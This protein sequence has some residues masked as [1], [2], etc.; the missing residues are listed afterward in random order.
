M[1]PIPTS[2]GI[3][4]PIS[5]MPIDP[6]VAIGKIIS[7][8]VGFILVFASIW[9]LFQLLQAGLQ[10]IGSGGDKAGLEGARDRITHS[11]LGLLVV[12]SAW[13]IYILVLSFLGLSPIG[14]SGTVNFKIPSFF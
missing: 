9:T 2:G 12:F 6:G 7:G 14:P 11:L 4:P 1:T 3:L 8:V 5:G 10:W 13:A